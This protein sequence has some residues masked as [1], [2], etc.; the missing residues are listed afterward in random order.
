[1]SFAYQYGFL[2]HCFSSWIFQKSPKRGRNHCI[3][4]TDGETEAGQFL[5]LLSLIHLKPMS[6]VIDTNFEF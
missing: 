2:E 4:F 3:R 1:M 5:L 6:L